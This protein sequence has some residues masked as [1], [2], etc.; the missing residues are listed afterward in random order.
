MNAEPLVAFM[1]ARHDIY[2]KRSRGH[3]Y[4]WSPDIILNTYKFTNVYRQLDRVT[5]WVMRNISTRF[6]GHHN[7]WFMLCIARQ[8]N[9]PDSLAEL[10]ED[11]TAWPHAKRLERWDPERLRT[12]LNERKARG[13]QV[14]TGAYMLT[15]VLDRTADG[16]HDK[17]HFT[18]YRVLC[19]VRA[20]EAEIRAALGVSMKTTH[21]QLSQGYGWGGFTAYEV[22]C[23]LRWTR[24]GLRWEDVN[25]FAHAG[26]GAAR[27]LNRLAG[28]ELN[29]PLRSE[30]ALGEMV[31]LL[32]VVQKAWWPASVMAPKLEL[33]EIEHSLCEFDKYE[34]VRL[35]QGKP[36]SRFIYRGN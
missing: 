24:H 32:P 22:C 23:D 1:R 25:T 29:S 21:A 16:P 20:M 33:R 18:A 34:R 7:L 12:I 15:N 17:P 3:Q 27:G 4:P 35:G 10:I 8:I 31:A 14:Y 19:S 36:R 2:M 11:K 30:A 26:P 5:Q 13:A 28:R 6:A 9:W